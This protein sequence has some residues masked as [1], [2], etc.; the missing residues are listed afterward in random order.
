VHTFGAVAGAA[1]L[2]AEL[3]GAQ[4]AVET[5]PGKNGLVSYWGYV[6]RGPIMSVLTLDSLAPQKIAMP[7]F[8]TLLSRA[9]AKITAL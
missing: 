6:Q 7:E 5:V 8:R 3:E 1:H 2:S 4:V 9:A